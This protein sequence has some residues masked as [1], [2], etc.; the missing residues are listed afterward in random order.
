[1]TNSVEETTTD[2]KIDRQGFDNELRNLISSKR[3]DTVTLNRTEY[4][5]IIQCLKVV[6]SNP[7]KTPLDY[8]RMAM[9][10]LY[11][12]CGVEKL[13]NPTKKQDDPVPYFAVDDK[14]FELLASAHILSAHG[15]RN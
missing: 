6:K 9:Y 11:S 3:D 14:M 7:V 5:N 10:E 4:N 1:M 8:K 13:I 12:E 15:G 2:L